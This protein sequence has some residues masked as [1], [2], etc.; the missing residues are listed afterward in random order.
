MNN[1]VLIILD[2]VG[3]GELPDASLYSDEGSNTIV[4]TA[5]FVG[6]L[7]LPNLQKLGLGNITR[8]K[9][10]HKAPDPKAS[11]G[12]MKEISKGKDSTTGHW[13]IGGLKVDLEFSYFPN[14]FPN[15]LME[16]FLRLS[17]CKGY[18]GNKAASGTEI[19]QEFG[20]EHI[21]TGFPIVYTSADSV[22]Q[23][24]SHEEIIS[25][26][27]L[28]RICEITRNAVLEA[29][30]VIGRVIARPFTGNSG[31]YIR[32]VNRKDFSINPPR[33]TILDLLSLNGIQTIGIGKVNDLF[34]YQ[35]I[36]KS[37]Q[38][39]SNEE[40]INEI[41]N[42]TASARNSFIFANLVDFDVYFGH[43]NDP[44]GFAEALRYFDFRLPEIIELLD[45]SD[46]LIITADHG[47][48]PT[49]PSTDH[50]R[51][52][53]PLIFYRKNKIGENLGIR[54]TFSDIAKT[55]GDFFSVPNNLEG[56]SFL[57]E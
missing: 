8:I 1:F 40:G 52:F 5:N 54:D 51:E 32:T 27:N 17:G 45:E 15:E 19:I 30:I 57:H 6:G 35:G 41:K 13:E 24:A 12:K 4:N 2:G 21:K 56:K 31:N 7:N 18:L 25:L 29:P 43:R 47:N 33:D 36:T 49:T 55:I 28:Y 16:K 39:K 20:D 37:V 46:A 3:I 9:G 53:I 44:I 10:I 22:F 42:F 14:G 26:K 50:S 34:N 38:T 11:F 48:D 23:I